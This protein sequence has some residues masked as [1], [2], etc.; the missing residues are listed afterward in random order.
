MARMVAYVP[1]DLDFADAAPVRVEGETVADVDPAAV[2]DVLADHR[3]W[4]EWWGD[5]IIRVEPTSEVES[6]VGSTR[7]VVLKPNIEFD[8]RFIA[9]EPDV[10]WAFTVV[11]GPR[12]IRSVVERC[13][14]HVEGPGRTRVTYRMAI[15][16]KPALGPV[17]PLLRR[18]LRRSLDGAV[19]RL[20]AE[21]R[22]RSGDQDGLHDP[23]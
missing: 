21:A 14:I 19:E 5:P 13:T 11:D 16:P 18:G 22:R 9:W 23:T 7:V 2:W 4:T 20:V 1:Q 3:R 17:L 10:L 8:E 12:G 15:D 6:G